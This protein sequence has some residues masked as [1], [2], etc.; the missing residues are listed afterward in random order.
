METKVVE[1]TDGI[2]GWEGNVNGYPVDI[3]TVQTDVRS[4]F[5]PNIGI[6]VSPRTTYGKSLYYAEVRTYNDFKEGSAVVRVFN[7]AKAGFK[8]TV[9]LWMKNNHSSFQPIPNPY[10]K[11]IFDRKFLDV[12]TKD[13]VKMTITFTDL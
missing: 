8:V 12:Y 1:I 9:K 13:L 6:L 4:K 7:V 11:D 10:Y 2:F 3:T 5:C